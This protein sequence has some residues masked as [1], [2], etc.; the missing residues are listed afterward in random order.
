MIKK[1]HHWV[2]WDDLDLERTAYKT[3][4][5]SLVFDCVGVWG[6]LLPED[7]SIERM[8]EAL[9][10]IVLKVSIVDDAQKRADGDNNL[11]PSAI[12][13]KQ[14]SDIESKELKWLR[15][16]SS[17]SLH[18]PKLL[19]EFANG[20]LEECLDGRSLKAAQMRDMRIAKGVMQAMSHLHKTHPGPLSNNDLYDRV[21]RWRLRAVQS[22]IAGFEEYLSKAFADDLV[23]K[24]QAVNSP[25]VLSHNDLQMGNIVLER[26]SEKII[27][28]DY[29]Y[30][31]I[32]PRGY[33][34][35]N[36][37]CEWM[38]DYAAED[39][40]SLDPGK[41]PNPDQITE[42]LASYGDD[43]RLEYKEI[44]PFINLSHYLWT[45]W[46]I[47]QIAVNPTVNFDFFKYAHNRAK[48]INPGRKL[49]DKTDTGLDSGQP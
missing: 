41:F 4:I 29:E 25:L 43:D 47:R 35:A 18:A 24:C 48:M 31:N 21:E 45:C 7:I 49:D 46:S 23:K 5:L 8:T 34:I 9:S 37:F 40:E 33:D 14:H 42:L 36:Y 13:I 1:T 27:L 19:A 30:C 3:A 20:H 6:S 12:I 26:K 10:N 44:E 16:I 17:S 38:T 39:R 28:I 22:G 2:P 11:E 32:S 15:I